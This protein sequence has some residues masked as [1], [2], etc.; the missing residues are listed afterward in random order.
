MSHE[1]TNDVL[2]M[3]SSVSED[4]LTGDLDEEKIKQLFIPYDTM[5]FTTRSGEVLRVGYS[6][7][8]L[9][10]RFRSWMVGPWGV[11]LYEK[12]MPHFGAIY[13]FACEEEEKAIRLLPI[14]SNVDEIIDSLQSLNFGG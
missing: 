8:P 10:S 6:I 11:S 13:V 14:T 9:P 3:I 12:N 5:P 4:P 7:A 1:L 2:K